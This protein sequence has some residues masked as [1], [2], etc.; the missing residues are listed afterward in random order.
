MKTY[1][2]SNSN[3]AETY[4]YVIQQRGGWRFW[5]KEK[6]GEVLHPMAGSPFH[7]V[8]KEYQA[9]IA[10][11]CASLTDAWLDVAAGRI[12][13]RAPLLQNTPVTRLRAIRWLVEELI[14]LAQGT[15]AEQHGF[16]LGICFSQLE[17]IEK[18]LQDEID[19]VRDAIDEGRAEE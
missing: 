16:N 7:A 4:G 6:P 13:R 10:N 5:D 14:E 9:L 2:V 15:E 18:E 12:P 1:R 19:H 11:G 8:P 3:T 17:L